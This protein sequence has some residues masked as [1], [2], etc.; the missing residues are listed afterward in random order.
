MFGELEKA[1]SENDFLKV[2]KKEFDLKIIKHSELLN[3]KIKK[4]AFCGGSGSFL[5]KKA[6]QKKADIFI[7]ADFSYHNFLTL[8]ISLL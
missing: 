2:L 3:K 7:S 4:V 5:L 8:T 1:I 6:I